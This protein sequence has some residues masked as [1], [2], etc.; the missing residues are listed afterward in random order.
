MMVVTY[1]MQDQCFY[2]P[3]QLTSLDRFFQI[4]T[5]I[6]QLGVV[7]CML[8]LTFIFRS[9]IY[10]EYLLLGLVLAH[11]QTQKKGSN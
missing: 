5:Q 4:R 11:Q 6:N 2:D 1:L 8:N 7:V 9:F 10:I 3:L